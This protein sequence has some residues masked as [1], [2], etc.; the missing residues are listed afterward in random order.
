MRI[1]TSTLFNAN[2]AQLNTLQGDMLQTQQQVASGRAILTPADNPVAAAQA[3]QLTQTDATNTQ[4]MSNISMA[5][6]SQTLASGVLQNMNTLMQSVHTAVISAGN[7]GMT[8]STRQ[9]L[10]TTLQANL[11]QLTAMA[12][13]QDSAGNYM[14]S[15][16]K[17]TTQ[18]FVS[19]P[20]GMQYQGDDGQR[21]IQVSQNSQVAAS[22]SGANIFMR[23]K[24]GNGSYVTQA[25][26]TNTGTGI[27]SGGTL[28][29]PPP[30]AA[31]LANTYT[32][33]FTSATTY[34]VTGVP[35]SVGLPVGAQA[36]VSGQ[37]ISFN[38]MQFNI[39]GAPASGDTF[40]AAPSTNQSVFTTISNFITA[41]NT[42]VTSPAIGAQLNASI[43][44]AL[45][46]LTNAMN[47]VSTANAA[48]GSNLNG[49][50]ALTSAEANQ[51]VQYKAA[52]S[53]LQDVNMTQAITDLTQQQTILK[54]AQQSFVSVQNLSMFNYMR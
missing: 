24:N 54:A 28:T 41:L 47:N 46:G 9:S 34:T 8:D 53:L 36:Y 48:V 43:Q 3:L 32:I 37:A 1:S 11:D 21:M 30:T 38:G 23:I 51:G 40:T 27:I 5:Q 39:S 25:T 50:A 16:F 33:N 45:S 15:G 6:N 13:S 44:S 4:Y 2:V 31:Q 10:A 17:G 12:N 19:T 42:P 29:V 7:P 35:S 49:M 26:A 52:L 18:P 20:T 22:S 14:F